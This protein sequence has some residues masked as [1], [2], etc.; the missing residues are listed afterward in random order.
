M[1]LPIKFKGI[2]LKFGVSFRYFNSNTRNLKFLCSKCK[3]SH[4]IRTISFMNIFLSQR[5]LWNIYL[6]HFTMTFLKDLKSIRPEALY[7]VT[8]YYECIPLNFALSSAAIFLFI[9]VLLTDS[10]F[11]KRIVYFII[12]FN[13]SWYKGVGPM[14]AID[15]EWKWPK[16]R[17]STLLTKWLTTVIRGLLCN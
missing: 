7:C 4:S 6:F 1:I 3:I 2:H 17:L 16:T 13:F 5:F 14:L 8:V 9:H 11:I 15:T 10:Y 12:F